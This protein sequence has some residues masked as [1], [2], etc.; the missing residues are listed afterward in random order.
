MTLA[1]CALY[2]VCCLTKLSPNFNILLLGRVLGGV[3]TS[4]LFSAFE[5]WLVHEHTNHYRFPA[6]WLS[7]TFSKATFFNGLLAIAAGIVAQSASDWAGF[8]PVAP[9]VLAIPCLFVAFIII[10]Y[11][12]EENY[13]EKNMAWGN[14]CMEGLVT[15]FKNKNILALGCVQALFEANMYIFV[16][17]WTP[18]LEPGRPPLGLTFSSFMLAIMVGSSLY[19]I[20][21]KYNYT[22]EEILCLC[23][24]LMGGSLLVCVWSREFLYIDYLSFLVLEVSVGLYFPCIGKLRADCI[25]DGLR[26]NI[27]NWFRVPMNILTCGALLAMHHVDVGHS[28]KNVTELIFLVCGLAAFLGLAVARIFARLP[29][30]GGNSSKDSE[31][32]MKDLIINA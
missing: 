13:G 2:I 25:P 4:L 19:T 11:R 9:F 6:D 28:G 5:T 22:N 10:Y 18:V 8:G 20:L 21:L 30:T 32:D 29:R 23:M 27:M 14:S 16:F 15:I 24:T 1:F 31:E 3:S 26:A 12:W 17:L 7:L